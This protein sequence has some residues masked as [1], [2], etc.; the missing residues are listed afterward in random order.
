MDLPFPILHLEPTTIAL[1]AQMTPFQ[2]IERL[3][4]MAR[5]NIW[6]PRVIF[7]INYFLP[8]GPFP[9]D[10]SFDPRPYQTEVQILEV[11]KPIPPNSFFMQTE[12]QLSR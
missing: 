5:E 10:I 11:W 8:E 4:I 3:N 9:L 7:G 1:E 6:I 2:K 12:G